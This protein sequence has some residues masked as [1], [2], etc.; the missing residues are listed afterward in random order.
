[1]AS[2]ILAIDQGTSSTRAI[3]FDPEAKPVASAQ[4]ELEQHFPQPGWVEHDATEI[5]NSTIS[6]CRQAVERAGLAL[7]EIAGIGIANQR[8]TTVVWERASGRPVA[9]AIVWQCR[10]TAER[11]AELVRDGLSGD[12]RTRTG[13]VVD[14]YFSA[15]KLEWLLE[16][17]PNGRRRAEDGDLCFGT[18]DTWLLYRLTGGQ[19][20]ATDVTNAARTM[21]L[22]IHDLEWDETLLD[23]FGVPVE[24]LPE[25]RPSAS[26]FGITDAEVF[27]TAIP[28]AGI[29]GDQHAAL[30][31][32]ACFRAGM[33][34]CTYGTGAF[35]LTNT[36]NRPAESENGLLTTLAWQ[37]GGNRTYAL[38]GSI[39]TTGATVQWL[40][41]G[42]GIVLDVSETDELA[43]T[44]DS[45]EGIYLVPAFVGLGAPY[46]DTDARG[47]ITGLTLGASGAHLARAAL[48]STAYQV[49]DVLQ[50][51]A[52]DTGRK[53]SGPLRVDGGQ[54]ANTFLMQFQADILDREI[55]VA[56]ISET[57]AL[58]AAFLAG[59]TLGVWD[60]EADLEHY[61][62]PSARYEP[63][64]RGSERER[65][66]SGW[67]QAVRQ[68][69]A[70]RG[71]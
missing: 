70:G 64:M 50:A 67:R 9:N 14:A 61:W 33:S 71:G 40:R 46:W 30:F 8:E 28:I 55:E 62:T 56:P 59:L 47:T 25:I 44:V 21:L 16:R 41:D 58:G 4:V 53:A 24:M 39:F 63:Q 12:I 68:A 48:E 66:Y 52:A 18:I 35:L 54:T 19:T 31:G 49:R 10:R 43:R 38:E 57:T 20:H 1:M 7:D 22:N 17:I 37:L 11:C 60:G 26:E 34:K 45:N 51:V 69:R 23:L 6:V 15:T 13:L 5:L 27:G 2:H 3:V 32:Q 65:L 42:L 29:A 36:G